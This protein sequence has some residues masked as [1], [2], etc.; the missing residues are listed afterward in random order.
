V[1]ALCVGGFTQLANALMDRTDAN[2]TKTVLLRELVHAFANNFAAIAALIQMK[3][4]SI[5]DAKAKS[6]LK[7]AIEQVRVMARVH[8]RLRTGGNDVTLDSK[9]FFEELCGSLETSMARG[10]SILIRCNTDSCP[11]YMEQALTLGLIINELVTNAIKHAFPDRRSGHIHVSFKAHTDQSC[12]V[13]DDN[14]VGFDE[15][16]SVGMGDDLV[17]GLSRQLGGT[18]QIQSSK[19]GT[20]FRLIISHR[21]TGGIDGP[22]NRTE[23]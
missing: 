9:P 6:V 11:L 19:A 2:K 5:S 3:S 15:Q 22:L 17:K 4:E 12:L 14:G 20:S 8:K 7:D 21:R 10:Q 1:A 18:L 23:Q 13:V 16:R